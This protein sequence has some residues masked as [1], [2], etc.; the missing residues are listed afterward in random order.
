MQHLI[1]EM[2]SK[3]SAL[4]KFQIRLRTELQKAPEGMLRVISKRNSFYYYRRQNMKDKV[5]KYI[6]KKD[7]PLIKAL[8]QKEYDIKALR[9]TSRNIHHL[10]SILSDLRNYDPCYLMNLVQSLP[11]SR[12]SLIDPLFQTDE[13]YLKE[14]Q[15]AEYMGKSFSEDAPE[16][17]TAKGER[18]RSKSEIL[19]ADRLSQMGIPYRY[20]Y[21]L[22]LKG[23]GTIYPD[24]LLLN[25]MLRKEVILE[26]FGLVDQPEY[27]N[28]MARK[29]ESYEKNGYYLGENLLITME[30]SASPLNMR[31]FEKL[32]QHHFFETL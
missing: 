13:E 28:N 3:I 19:I 23:Y 1:V 17:Y 27:A 9:Q 15:S 16:Y 32:I 10:N 8:A 31:T 20:E 6:S 4:E 30:T 5:G 21:P 25:L 2:E 29:I 26:H 22:Y 11:D 7:L 18:V 24:F 12:K 14:W